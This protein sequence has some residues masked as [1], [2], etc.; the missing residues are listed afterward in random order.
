MRN[1]V[2]HMKTLTENVE[3]RGNLERA[4]IKIEAAMGESAGEELENEF[5]EAR[6]LGLGRSSEDKNTQ[7]ILE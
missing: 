3:F 7:K 5:K 1:E 2:D 4:R 6:T